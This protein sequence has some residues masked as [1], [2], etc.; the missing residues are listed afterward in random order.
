MVIAVLGMLNFPFGT[1]IGVYA[2]LVLSQ[3][4]AIDCFAPRQTA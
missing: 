2:L 3:Q 4:S 1:V